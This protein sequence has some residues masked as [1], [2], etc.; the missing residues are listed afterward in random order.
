MTWSASAG[1]VR[2]TS[3]PWKNGRWWTSHFARTPSG[4]Q[5]PPLASVTDQ[6][7]QLGGS[8]GELGR[9]GGLRRSV[10]GEHLAVQR[11]RERRVR[12]VEVD[13]LDRSSPWWDMHFP[14]RDR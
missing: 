13:R 11:D 7:T 6:R 14:A 12:T 8:E 5:A 10:D 4:N 3:W 2:V 9:C 1:T